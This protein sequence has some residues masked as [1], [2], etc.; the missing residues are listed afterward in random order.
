MV[1]GKESGN[2]TGDFGVT[3]P[4]RVEWCIAFATTQR[5]QGMRERSETAFIFRLRDSK[6]CSQSNRLQMNK[7]ERHFVVV[8]KICDQFGN[9]DMNGVIL[10]FVD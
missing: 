10:I 5:N 9:D 7:L 4:S 8:E 1:V 2:F 6:A 3:A